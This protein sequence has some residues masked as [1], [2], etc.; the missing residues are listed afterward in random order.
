MGTGC[1]DSDVVVIGGGPGGCAAA[2]TCASMGLRVLLTERSA[3]PVERPG[4]T[5]HPGVE[6]V[7][8]QL[9]LADR[10]HSVVGSR[11]AGIQIEW[12]KVSRFESYGEDGSGQWLGFQVWRS[13][14]DAMLLDRAREVGVKILQPCT[15][16][17]V[18]MTRGTV[19][20]VITSAGEVTAPIVVDAS[21]RS[22]LLGTSLGIERNA[23]SPSMVARYGYAEGSLPE[24]DLA[25]SLRGD[26]AGWLWKAMIR[27]GLY[28][29]TQVML[30]GTRLPRDWRPEE[31][32]GLVPR[33]LPRGADVTWRLAAALAGPGWFS[34]GDAAAVLDPTSANGV[35][36]ALLSGITAGKLACGVRNGVLPPEQAATI[37]NDW[38]L[39]WF[40]SDSTQLREFY[41]SLGATGF[42]DIGDIAIEVSRSK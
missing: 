2:I 5:L 19:T 31:F 16:K 36:R 18:L 34:V 42:A 15:V 9:G 10:L 4:E 17:K 33:G 29:W 41:R 24:L 37:Y 1:F 27:P 32:R 7:L 30:D 6:S 8:S 12:G 14:F 20:R 21:G 26:S 13:D 40:H 22:H 28:H 35:L 39:G 25:P 38:F 11:H 23:Y 3:F